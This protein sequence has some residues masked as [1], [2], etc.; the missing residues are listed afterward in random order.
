MYYTN[1][2]DRLSVSASEHTPAGLYNPL[3]YLSMLLN[4]DLSLDCSSWVCTL[5]SNWCII[6]D[7][8]RATVANKANLAQI[9]LNQNR[10]WNE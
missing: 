10:N 1:V 7:E 8:L 6:I 5:R 2:F 3:E 4:L 9:D